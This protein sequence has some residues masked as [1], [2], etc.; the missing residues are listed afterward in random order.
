MA[1]LG[2]SS[3]YLTACGPDWG[4]P[5][6]ERTET[7]SIAL[8]QSEE[9]HAELRM[10]AGELRVRGGSDKLMEGQF[11]YNRLRLRPEISY[12]A[13]G[14]RGHLVVQEPNHAGG[15]TRRYAWD[16]SFNNQKPLDLDVTCGAGESHLDLEDLTLRR[17]SIQM[18]V[19]ELRMDLRGQPKR[20]YSVHIH[21]GV[22]EATVY[23]PQG[24]GIEANVQGGIG[25][26]HAPG[27]QKRE[28][29]Y[30]NQAYGNA[31]TT[32]H[33]DVQGGIGSINLIAN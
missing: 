30:V 10:G 25:A 15:S 9:V 33:L 26:I 2:M 13:G 24:V 28:G 20:D 17:V 1:A 6:P 22:G 27:L 4:P 31:K 14:F 5:G 16:L 23:L 8:D 21:G 3:F 12:S 29:R 18:G 11:T 32:V 19:G 7:R